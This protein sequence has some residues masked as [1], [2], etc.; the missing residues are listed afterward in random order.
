MIYI[1]WHGAVR[2]TESKLPRGGNMKYSILLVEDEQKI[3]EGI[4]D[5]M[6]GKEAEYETCFTWADD[7]DKALELVYEN[8]YDLVLLDVMLPGADGF[9]ICRAIRAK[10]YVPVIFLTARGREEDRLYGYDIGCDDYVVKPFS[11][12]ELS[13]KIMSFLRRSKGLWEKKSSIEA[14]DIVIYPDRLQVFAAGNEV[15]LAPKEY[16]MLKYFMEHRGMLITR[17]DLLVRLWGYD[18]EGSDR[19]VDNHIK[20]LRQ[21]IGESGKKIK[22]VFAK[23]YRMD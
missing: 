10:S 19:V 22:T 20:K 23:G 16:A 15:R 13:A 8:E 14:Y 11:M 9:E 12:A 4:M 17:D 1:E 6:N 3:A 2:Y 18:Y 21:A 7:G 5:Y